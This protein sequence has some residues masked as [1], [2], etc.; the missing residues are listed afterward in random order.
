MKKEISCAGS[1]A[2]KQVSLIK[3]VKTDKEETTGPQSQL[4]TFYF[5]FSTCP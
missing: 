1:S 3:K 2:N 5:G 4:M